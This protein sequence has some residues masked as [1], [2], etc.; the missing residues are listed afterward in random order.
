MCEYIC[1]MYSRCEDERLAFIRLNRRDPE[2]EQGLEPEEYWDNRFLPRTFHG[3]LAWSSEMVARC[4]ALARARGQG[5]FFITMT[6]SVDWP[7]I[8]AALH[9]NQGPEDRADV[10][11]RVWHIKLAKFVARLKKLFPVQSFMLTMRLLINPSLNR[12]T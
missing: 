9:P 7:E 11:M 2:P 12:V 8:R 6:C 10:I 1:D 4:H 3:S 5:T